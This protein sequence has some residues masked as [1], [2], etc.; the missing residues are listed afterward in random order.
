M[1]EKWPLLL[2]LLLDH[3]SLATSCRTDFM[4]KKKNNNNT[5]DVNDVKLDERA[6]ESRAIYI[7][8]PIKVSL[9]SFS[10]RISSA[11]IAKYEN[12]VMSATLKNIT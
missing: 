3:Q 7:G 4:E 12:P 9:W 1:Q 8:R 11:K 6:R 10:D 2:L 5:T